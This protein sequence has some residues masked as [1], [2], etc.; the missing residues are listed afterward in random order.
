MWNFSLYGNCSR[1]YSISNACYPQAGRL[2]SGVG[3]E[4]LITWD[5]LM[6]RS[7]L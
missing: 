5:G 3:W 1:Y 7:D 4:A 2:T 6:G